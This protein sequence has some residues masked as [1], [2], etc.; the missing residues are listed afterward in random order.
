VSYIAADKN[1]FGAKDTCY[2]AHSEAVNVD[3]IVQSIDQDDKAKRM[4]V[5]ESLD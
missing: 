2:V 1:I 4:K 5:D 3:N